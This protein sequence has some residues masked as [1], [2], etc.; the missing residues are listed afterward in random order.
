MAL[1][2]E[3]EPRARTQQTTSNTAIQHLQSHSGTYRRSFGF[4]TG[5]YVALL[6]IDQEVDP[7]D[8]AWDPIGTGVLV[9]S[10][11]PQIQSPVTPS[12][13]VVKPV[14][15]PT[16]Q[17]FDDIYGSVLNQRSREGLLTL[18]R[19]VNRMLNAG[20]FSEALG[21]VRSID[22]QRLDT[23]LTVGV[24]TCLFPAREKFGDWGSLYRKVRERLQEIAPLRVASLLSGLD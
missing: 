23:T 11:S 21:T 15:K 18:Y 16:P 9:L 22:L 24:L 12:T 1:N 14:P 5:G 19:E 17:W 2:T 3:V 8:W 13:S 6:A 7:A 4:D 10:L 20:R